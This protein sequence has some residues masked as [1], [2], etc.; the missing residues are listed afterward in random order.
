[1]KL[2]RRFAWFR[3]KPASRRTPDAIFLMSMLPLLGI[4]QSIT[5]VRPGSI[6]ELM[7]QPAVIAWTASLIIFGTVS[8]IGILIPPSEN[9]T[10]MYLEMVGR[11][12]IAG[13]STVY[14]VGLLA[15]AGL[16]GLFPAGIV[17][18]ITLACGVR[19]IQLSI[20]LHDLR[21][22]IDVALAALRSA[23]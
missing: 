16:Y 5:G 22:Q 17:T 7:S 20:Y 2:L 19:A 10:G 21:R 23:D 11:A 15:S 6:E 13:T 8:L 9:I 12:V 4:Q 3:G 14:V 18:G 1:M